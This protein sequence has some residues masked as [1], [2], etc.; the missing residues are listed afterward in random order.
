MLYTP[1]NL[2]YILIFLLQISVLYNIYDYLTCYL[3]SLNLYILIVMHDNTKVNS[4]HEQIHSSINRIL[5]KCKSNSLDL[6]SYSLYWFVK[7]V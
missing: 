2:E 1:F 3:F 7:S 4:L 6:T 5:L